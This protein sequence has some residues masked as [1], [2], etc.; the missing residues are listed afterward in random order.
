M[1]GYRRSQSVRPQ[2]RE[3]SDSCSDGVAAAQWH[4]DGATLVGFVHLETSTKKQTFLLEEGEVV[5][6]SQGVFL[7]VNGL[8]EVVARTQSGR[9]VVQALGSDEGTAEVH[10]SEG[11]G[12]VMRSGLPVLRIVLDT[13]VATPVV[14]DLMQSTSTSTM[15]SAA[16]SYFVGHADVDGWP[17]WRINAASGVVDLKWT[18]QFRPIGATA[19]EDPVVVGYSQYHSAATCTNSS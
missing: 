1:A 15:V 4:E 16:G 5:R 3:M 18:P 2:A 6:F 7:S 8:G 19:K 11:W 14:F 9:T 12:I 10:L 17:D 13:L